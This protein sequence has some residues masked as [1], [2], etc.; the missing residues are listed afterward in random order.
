MTTYSLQDGCVRN[1]GP[2]DDGAEE[3]DERGGELHVVGSEE[4][5][6]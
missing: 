2:S 1:S 6:E 3:G 5:S 4:S